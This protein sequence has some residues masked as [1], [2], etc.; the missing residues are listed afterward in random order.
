MIPSARF[1]RDLPG[2]LQP[3]HGHLGGL[4]PAQPPLPTR[5]GA[6]GKSKQQPG[7]RTLM[8]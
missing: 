2:V 8:A 5:Q 7:G 1:D 4:H 6:P 3:P